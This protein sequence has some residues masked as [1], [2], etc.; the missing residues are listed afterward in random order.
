MVNVTQLADG[1]CPGAVHAVQARD[2]MLV[3]IRVPGGF[4]TAGQFRDVARLSELYADGRIDITARA[5]LQLRGISRRAVARLANGLAAAGLLP[6]ATHERVR[7]VVA[8][9]F[10]GVDPDELVDVRPI[11]SELDAGLVADS[12]LA[13]LPAKFCF[14]LDGGGRPFDS[15]RADLALR[16]VSRGGEICF[17]LF[18]GGRS[19][20]FAVAPQH[21]A[22]TLLDG[23]RAA[24][25]TGAPSR[26][27]RLSTSPS[28]CAAVLEALAPVVFSARYDDSPSAPAAAPLGIL[29]AGGTDRA[30]LVPSI[31]LGRLDAAR[32]RAVAMLVE[33]SGADLRLTPWRGIVIGAVPSDALRAIVDALEALGLS[34]ERPGG[35][36]GVAACAGIEGCSS[37]HADVRRDAVSLAR[38][39]AGAPSPSSWSVNVAGCEK[40][41]GMRRGASVELVASESGYDVCID[42]RVVRRAATAETALALTV[43]ARGVRIAEA[44]R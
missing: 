20:G 37:A 6:S 25:A 29:P 38:Q 28:A 8:S 27:W 1:R 15:S 7:N 31:P 32:A 19:S 10:S 11:V 17:A 44:A 18:V 16:A 41:C 39:L 35:Y 21:A 22:R 12:F 24:L 2:G 26:V 30:N 34:V 43:A 40:R 14:A 13:E 4:L 3:R 42:G 9:P 5:N 23:A 33:T 36:A